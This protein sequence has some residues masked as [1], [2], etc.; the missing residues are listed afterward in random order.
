MARY[1]FIKITYSL[2]ESKRLF[3]L[4]RGRKLLLIYFLLLIVKYQKGISK[5]LENILILVL[6][7]RNIV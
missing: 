3:L 1:F 5:F 7:V 2:L 4:K 6:I